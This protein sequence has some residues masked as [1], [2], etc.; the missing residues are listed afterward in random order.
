ML[1]AA[2]IMMLE[3]WEKRTTRTVGLLRALKEV[4]METNNGF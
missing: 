3:R 2:D 4:H 1:V